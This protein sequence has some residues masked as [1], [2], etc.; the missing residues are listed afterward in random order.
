MKIFNK[1]SFGEKNNKAAV[2]L[3]RW[4][5]S[6]R[7]M[8]IIVCAVT[9]SL[10]FGALIF[11]YGFD[12]K[13]CALCYYQRWPHVIAAI[14]AAVA[15]FVSQ[16]R[17]SVIITTAAGIV[18]LIG[19]GIAFFHA[20]VEYRWWTYNSSCITG[21]NLSETAEQLLSAIYAKTN[22]PCDVPQWSLLGI[23]MAGYNFVISLLLGLAAVTA[24]LFRRRF[25]S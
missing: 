5:F 2:D 11:Q 23:T 13:P 7:G 1:P 20:G 3:L 12:L 6:V 22:I 16:K 10:F 21:E 15:I 4:A 19:A 17:D 18:V 8:A 25:F 24:P 9:A 14:L